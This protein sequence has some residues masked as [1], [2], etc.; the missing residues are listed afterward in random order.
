MPADDQ[1]LFSVREFN[2]FYT[3]QIGVLQ[4]GL[5][6]SPYS[7]AEVRTMYEIGKRRSTTASEIGD[8]LGFDHGYLSRILRRLKLLDLVEKTRSIKDGRQLLLTLTRKGRQAYAAL[9]R[10]ADA[11]VRRLL[12][13][14]STEEIHELLEAMHTI[15]HLLNH[16]SAET[17][18]YVLRPPEPGDYGWMVAAHGDLYAREYGWN[19]E[20]E[21]LTAEIIADFIKHFNPERDRCWIA[22]SEGIPVGCVLAVKDG[23]TA[24]KLRLLLVTPRARGLGIGARLVAECVRFAK[25][26]GYSKLTLWTQQNLTAARKIYQRAGFKLVRQE[27]HHSFGCDLV[28][29]YWELE[30]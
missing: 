20:M 28:G 29:E 27:P 1:D 3:R 17:R 13:D 2:R 12:E 23:K 18:G 16:R 24:A 7:L 15:R 11:E 5:L 26:K 30:L 10:R 4:E 14:L 9:D 22:E 6:S 8:I 21:M 19:D 25:Q